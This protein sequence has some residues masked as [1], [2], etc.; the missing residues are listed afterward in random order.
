MHQLLKE[1]QVIEDNW[2]LA[3]DNLESLPSTGNVLLSTSQWQQFASELDQQQVPVGVWLEGNEEIPEFIESLL[4]LPVIAI[5][6]AKFVDGRGYSLA[7]L[8]RERYHYSGELRAIGDII[9][10]QL[11]LLKHSGFNAF[12]LSQDIDLEQAA[13]SLTDFSE[14][15]QT[16]NAQP[17]PLFRRR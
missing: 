7:R 14:N 16:T 4:Q 12:Q 17:I 6:F 13:A 5:K 3:E 8:L 1:G 10:D 2:T 9:R 11:Y 15:Y